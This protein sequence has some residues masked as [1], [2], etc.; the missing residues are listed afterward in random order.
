M[1]L[2]I[3]EGK[4]I[5]VTEFIVL[6]CLVNNNNTYPKSNNIIKNTSYYFLNKKATHRVRDIP[7]IMK[8]S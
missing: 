1:I 5:W 7:A 2:M 6:A 8:Y 4:V 3:M